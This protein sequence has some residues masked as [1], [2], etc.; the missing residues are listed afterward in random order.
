M[1]WYVYFFF[2]IK[3][4]FCHSILLCFEQS[5]LRVLL[6][7]FVLYFWTRFL[8]CLSALSYIASSSFFVCV[9][10]LYKLPEKQLYS[11]N[12]KP[13][14]EDSINLF[15][16][17]QHLWLFSEW[18]G[19][20]VCLSVSLI[21]GDPC[22]ENMVYWIVIDWQRHQPLCM[23]VLVCELRPSIREVR[24]LQA[25]LKSKYTNVNHNCSK[26]H[27]IMSSPLYCGHKWR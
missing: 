5:S 1:S 27:K 18:S 10:A 22:S 13:L 19:V 8:L 26:V 11:M 24:Q 25:H 15:H 3:C 23:C 9:F 20:C 4:R 21:T 14:L 6:F 12:I 17:L 2:Y 7:T 16:Y